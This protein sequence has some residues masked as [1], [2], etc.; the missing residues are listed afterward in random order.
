MSA[1]IAL[2]TRELRGRTRLF[3]SCA[4]LAVV[5]FLAALLPAARAH[6]DD[7]IAMVGGFLAIIVGAAVALAMGGSVIMRD[8]AERRMSFWFAKPVHPAA[9]WFGKASA[10]M[11]T[12]LLSFGIIAVPAMLA[13]GGAWKNYWLGETSVLGVAALGIAVLFLISHAFATVVRSR[14]ML[15]ALDFFFAIVAVGALLL[16]VWPVALGGAVEVTKWLAI[17]IT[18][19]VLFVLAIAPVWQLEHGRADI[20]RSHAAFSRFF[21][22]GIAVVLLVAGGY[23]WW[24]VSATPDDFRGTL[25]VE[26]PARGSRV[27]LSGTTRRRGDYTATFLVDRATGRY[28]RVPTPPWWGAEWSQDGRVLARLQPSGLFSMT[29]L[30]LYANGRGTGIP[31]GL[32]SHFV[33]SDDGTRAAVSDRN[34]ITVY[35][36]ATGRTLMSAAGFHPRSTSGFWFVTNDLL[37]V[38]EVPPLRITQLDVRTRTKTSSAPRAM[39]SPRGSYTTSVSGDGTRLFIGGPNVV[40]DART[41]EP[42][43]TIPGTYVYARMLND[44]SVAGI[45]Y[46]AGAPHLQLYAPD[47]RRLHDLALAPSRNV[48]ISGEIEGGKLIL[49]TIGAMYVVDVRRGA[50][51]RKLDGITG[52]FPRNSVDPRL[53][54]YAAG[55]ELAGRQ[56]RQFIVWTHDGRAETRPLLQ[57]QEEQR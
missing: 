33:L 25:L 46:A 37:R 49:A 21:W 20:R 51:E 31:L 48:W 2:F 54:R 40:V 19:A 42:L 10:A 14:S 5:P 18:A 43:A 23:V 16:L 28:E 9:L 7:V 6:Q 17:G 55:Q 13:G 38:I 11:L 22:P 35:D 34:T 15:L 52:P 4:V 39:S 50:I 45:S 57:S 47:G 29:S 56:N 32:G 24:L 41:G 12:C 8:L 44:G 30:E 3:L 36:V 1:A 26:Q 27:L 53:I